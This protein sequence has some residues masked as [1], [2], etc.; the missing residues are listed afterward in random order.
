MSELIKKAEVNAAFNLVERCK[1][2]LEQINDACKKACID[3]FEKFGVDCI[4]LHD[5]LCF[6]GFGEEIPDVTHVKYDSESQEIQFWI[7]TEDDNER[8]YDSMYD[9]TEVYP[10]L[11][12]SVNKYID[13]GLPSALWAEGLQADFSPV[14]YDIKEVE[15]SCNFEGLA[16]TFQNTINKVSC[17]D[18]TNCVMGFYNIESIKIPSKFLPKLDDND[19]VWANRDI[20]VKLFDKEVSREGV[21]FIEKDPCCSI[22]GHDYQFRCP[23][24]GRDVVLAIFDAIEEYKSKGL[25]STEWCGKDE[26]T[27]ALEDYDGG[28]HADF[29]IQE[30]QGSF[31]NQK[32]ISNSVIEV[33]KDGDQAPIEL[34]LYNYIFFDNR[35]GWNKTSSINLSE[36][37]EDYAVMF[38]FKYMIVVSGAIA[39]GKLIRHYNISLSDSATMLNELRQHMAEEAENENYKTVDDF[40]PLFDQLG[41][42][43]DYKSAYKED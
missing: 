42:W 27:R 43:Y 6:D 4:R 20:Y 23:Y 36:M 24:K 22:D 30:A 15:T 29:I 5:P 14:S 38:H 16:L 31:Y 40:C 7:I 37:T 9:L 10:I 33:S 32:C 17:D 34:C 3:L 1:E 35:N 12:Q 11:V 19:S 18:I 28:Y 26:H 25:P 13:A 2:T 41:I 8:N 39:I 21:T